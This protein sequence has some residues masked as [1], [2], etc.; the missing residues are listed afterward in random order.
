MI[1]KIAHT[2]RS[3]FTGLSR[4]TWLLSA[5]ILVNRAGTMV[6]PFMSMYLTQ[7][8]HR[9]VADAGMVITLFGVGAVLGS[10]AGGYLIDKIGFRPVQILSSII[11][12]YCLS[13]WHDQ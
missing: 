6:V 11:G 7:Q 5:I 13:F 8:L 9:S 3:S 1:L 4:E 12:G 2:Y 10:A